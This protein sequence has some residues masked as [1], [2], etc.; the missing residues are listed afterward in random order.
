MAAPYISYWSKNR[1]GAGKL[2]SGFV[3][4]SELSSPGLSQEQ[5]HEQQIKYLLDINAK[6]NE[7][8]DAKPPE[9]TDSMKPAEKQALLEILSDIRE[10]IKKLQK[11]AEENRAYFTELVAEDKRRIKLLETKRLQ[12]AQV[13]RGDI[14]LALLAANNGKMLAKEARH[15]MGLTKTRFSLLL[16]AMANKIESKEYHLDRR[17]SVLRLR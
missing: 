10:D 12:K 2:E 1:T 11:D 5:E 6:L 3:K 4:A 8:L 7:A 13:N 14:L 17:Q 16:S 9:S 15:K